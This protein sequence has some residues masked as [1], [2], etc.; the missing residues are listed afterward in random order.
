MGNVLTI[1]KKREIIKKYG[2]KK[3]NILSILL[4]LQMS[5]P[6]RCVDKDTTTFVAD[7]LGMSETRVY[8]IASYY[9]MLS[10]EPQAK[11][12]LQVC[13]S[14]PCH[15]SKSEKIAHILERQ[16]GI[17]VGETTPDGLFAIHYTPCVGACDVGPIIKVQDTIY[18]NL[19]EEKI[20]QLI[21]ELRVRE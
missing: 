9:S 15:F 13:N 11:Y 12:V 8:E 19:T 4:D 2:G 16:L 5:T 1:D 21:E 10:V 20:V 17:S 6:G 18:T 3:G 7:E 14:S